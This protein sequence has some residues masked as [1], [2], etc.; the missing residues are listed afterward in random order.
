M[1]LSYKSD[2]D[3]GQVIYDQLS[4]DNPLPFSFAKRAFYTVTSRSRKKFEYFTDTY[5]NFSVKFTAASRIYNHLLTCRAKKISRPVR[6]IHLIILKQLSLCAMHSRSICWKIISAGPALAANDRSSVEIRACIPR[7][8]EKQLYF[9]T[10]WISLCQTMLTSP[11]MASCIT[12]CLRERSSAKMRYL[13]S[14]LFISRVM[15]GIIT[16]ITLSTS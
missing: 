5:K 16:A 9:T 13:T 15:T 8:Y 7:R 6:E 3:N 11:L 4:S 12:I 10:A 1:G 14:Y 2:L